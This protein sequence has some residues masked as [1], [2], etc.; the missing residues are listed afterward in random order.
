MFTELI[1]GDKWKKNVKLK[2][3]NATDDPQLVLF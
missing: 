1:S 3:R 2:N